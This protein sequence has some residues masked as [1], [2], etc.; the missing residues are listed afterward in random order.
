MKKVVELSKKVKVE[1]GNDGYKIISANGSTIFLDED[2]EVLS[3]ENFVAEKKLNK[4]K[5][6]LEKF[7]KIGEEERELVSK[8][9]E[10]YPV[11]NEKKQDFLCELAVALRNVNY[12]FYVVEIFDTTTKVDLFD[13][14]KKIL[15]EYE[16]CRASEE[17]FVVWVAYNIASLK[18]T[19]EEALKYKH[20]YMQEKVYVLKKTK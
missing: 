8:K 1:V 5:A 7:T 12:D 13:N 17:E 10:L 9:T 2:G 14:C 16:V 4:R 3:Y 11:L 20:C 15:P 6:F 19:S 18:S